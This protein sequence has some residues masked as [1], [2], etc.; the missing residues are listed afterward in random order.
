[1]VLHLRSKHLPSLSGLNGL[2]DGL[3]MI[4]V[5]LL[6]DGGGDLLMTLRPDVLLGD[7]L[8]I[9]LIDDGLSLT[10]AGHEVR[11]ELLSF[12]HCLS[13]GVFPGDS[14]YKMCV[15]ECLVIVKSDV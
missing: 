3:V 7:G 10:I 13:T 14:C 6:V 5:N 1:M 15:R 4:L 12:L 11:N 9:I 8:A 2:N